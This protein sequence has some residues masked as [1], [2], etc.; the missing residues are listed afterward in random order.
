MRLQYIFHGQDKEP[1]PFHV[2]SNWEPP[3]Q[4]SFTLESYLEEVKTELAEVKISKPKNNLPNNERKAITS[5]LKKAHKGTTTVIM[6]WDSLR[7][8]RK[9]QAAHITNG[10]KKFLITFKAV[11]GLP[12]AYISD[13]ISVR[14][15]VWRHY[16][17]SNNGLHVNFKSLATLG[18]RSFHVAAP[19]LWND[20]PS[21]IRNMTSVQSFKKA[22]KTFLFLK[23]F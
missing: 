10:I 20:L 16:L 5:M 8:E 11:H 1:H 9:L 17:R 3:I 12:P 4:P 13:L 14:E 7:R 22:I 21:E 19:K 2:K 6:R 23:A 18:D 15:S